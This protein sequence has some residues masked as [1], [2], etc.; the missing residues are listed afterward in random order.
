MN[1]AITIFNGRY[2]RDRL[3]LINPNG[4]GILPQ[5]WS[6]T[7]A[8]IDPILWYVPIWSKFAWSFLGET[9][10]IDKRKVWS[11]YS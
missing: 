9:N 4:I 6:E 10:P 5:D 3:M 7:Y 8:D 2:A 11:D 1:H